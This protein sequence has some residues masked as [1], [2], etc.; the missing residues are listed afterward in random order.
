MN[1]HQ[2][3][4]RHGNTRTELNGAMWTA[5]SSSGL[6]WSLVRCHGSAWLRLLASHIQ[7][8]TSI[9]SAP[10]PPPH[11]WKLVDSSTGGCQI[12]A[13]KSE[14]ETRQERASLVARGLSVT[15]AVSAPWPQGP[16][17]SAL[18][19]RRI[20]YGPPH[21]P[22]HRQPL[23]VALR[24]SVSESELR[25]WPSRSF[26]SLEPL[27]DKCA[28]HEPAAH[29]CNALQCHVSSG[30]SGR[31]QSHAGRPRAT[32]RG[33]GCLQICSARRPPS[34]ACGLCKASPRLC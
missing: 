25:P 33:F 27:K 9:L 13:R 31:A 24:S 4:R 30:H 11:R 10:L 18:V 16:E 8:A 29:H 32:F 19:S 17:C 20:F 23:L 21:H 3:E 1:S 2:P 7:L 12:H 14:R 26:T 34:R 28:Q 6:L 22:R 5:A 15:L